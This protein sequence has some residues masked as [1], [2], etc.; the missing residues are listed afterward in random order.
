MGARAT[1]STLQMPR[2]SS[3]E[4]QSN[5]QAVTGSVQVYRHDFALR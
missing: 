5:N 3:S 1:P 2:V 4:K